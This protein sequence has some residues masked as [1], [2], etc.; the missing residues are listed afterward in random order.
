MGYTK[1]FSEILDSTV[2]RAGDS[3]RL[4]WITMLAM[5]D[6]NGEVMASVPGLADRAKVGMDECVAALETLK[7]PDE[8]SRSQEHDGRRIIEID[9][10][11]E[12]LNHA[13]YR[14]KASEEDRRE[15]SAERMRR[16]RERNAAS[17]DVTVRKS[18]TKNLKQKAEA[19]AEQTHSSSVGG[20]R[21]RSAPK[22]RWTRVPESWEPKPGH[23]ELA[24]ELGVSIQRELPKFRD[25]EFAKPKRDPDAA[26][27]TWLRN[28]EQFKTKGAEPEQPQ[29]GR[30]SYEIPT[31]GM[32]RKR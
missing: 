17:R 23:Q 29:S 24:R 27:R 25:H 21:K 1:L 5:A 16:Y 15:K 10:G 6:K 11:W 12:I 13:K 3:T 2:W 22:R 20:S 30:F 31:L 9:G 18:D 28:A 7:S 8:W 4:V 26:F 14:R 19:E 32:E